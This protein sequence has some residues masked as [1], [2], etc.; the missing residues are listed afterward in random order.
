M[1][2]DV[3]VSPSILSSDF[4]RLGDEVEAVLEA[5]ADWVH[6]DVMDGNFVDNLTIGVPVVKSLRS[7]FDCVMDVHMMV[8][9][10][11]EQLPWYLSFDVDYATVHIETLDDEGLLEASNTIRQ[12]GAKAGVALKPDTPIQR[13]APTLH[14]WDLVLVMSVFPGFSGQAFRPES[15]ERISELCELCR[16]KGLSPLIQVDGGI[17]AQTA[18]LVVDA[19]ADVLVAGNAVFKAQS[20]RDAINSL[21]VSPRSEG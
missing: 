19:G 17:N 18:E 15:P 5:G 11:L 13:L 21:R 8:A 6:V 1:F 16:S 2:S 20:Y 10:P 7:R 9:N 14:A 3:K 12:A 4:L